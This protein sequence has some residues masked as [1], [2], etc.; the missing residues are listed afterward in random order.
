MREK[1]SF[2]LL[3]LIASGFQV[4]RLLVTRM[5]FLLQVPSSASA[6]TREPHF[7]PRCSWPMALCV[8]LGDISEFLVNR[9]PDIFM[10]DFLLENTD[11]VLWASME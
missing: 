8:H 9:N 7:D 11:C 10:L 5:I 1:N 3:D 6:E 4:I 2:Q